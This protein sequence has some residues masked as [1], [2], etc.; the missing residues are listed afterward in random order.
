MI[1][2]IRAELSTGEIFT[3]PIMGSGGGMLGSGVIHNGYDFAG[4]LAL[5]VL[6]LANR[7]A[8]IRASLPVFEPRRGH[9]AI[10]PDFC[11]ESD[12]GRIE[13]PVAGTAFTVIAQRST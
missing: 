7:C 8:E 2:R 13:I 10:Y 5:D 4:K 11:A 1:V 12:G 3:G 9:V 6:R